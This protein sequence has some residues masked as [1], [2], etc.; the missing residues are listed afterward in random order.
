MLFLSSSSPLSIPVLFSLL[1]LPLSYLSLFLP[2]SLSVFFSLRLFHFGVDDSVLWLSFLSCPCFVLSVLS[3]FCPF[4]PVLV[5]SPF[6]LF[7]LCCSRLIVDYG[8]L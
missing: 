6:C 2:F 4:C 5:L 8:Y 1:C 7:V 3:L